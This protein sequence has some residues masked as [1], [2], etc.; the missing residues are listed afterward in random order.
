VN[1]ISMAEHRGRIRIN[2]I[3]IGWT[4]T[5]GEDAIQRQ[6]HAGDDTW[7]EEANSTVPIGRLGQIDEIADFAVLLLSDRS[8]VVTRSVIDWDRYVAGAHD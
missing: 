2:G 8:G 7:L 5:Q 4:E 6:F 1:I 3:N